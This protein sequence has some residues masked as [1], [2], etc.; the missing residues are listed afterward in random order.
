[1]VEV[2]EGLAH[3]VAGIDRVRIP[4][5]MVE[6][7]VEA[8]EEF[9]HRQIGFGIAEVDGRIEDHRLSVA[10]IGEIAAPQVAMQ[11]RRRGAVV[12]QCRKLFQQQFSALLQLSVMAHL[13][14]Q[15]QLMPQAPFAP[16]IDP[17]GHPAV[18]LMG[19]ANEIVLPPTETVTDCSMHSRQPFSGERG[20]AA[21]TAHLDI[22]DGQPGSVPESPKQ[23]GRGVRRDSLLANSNSPRTLPRTFRA[24]RRDGLDKQLWFPSESRTARLMQ[25]PLIECGRPGVNGCPVAFA[26]RFATLFQSIIDTIS[27]R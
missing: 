4:I 1:M 23:I 24:M 11:Q 15:F 26:I 19:G 14:S 5:G 20:I 16:E 6:I 13:R 12:E 2:I 17:V 21:D 8:A 3:G 25:P 9:G 18:G 27:F 10:G 7:R 22:F